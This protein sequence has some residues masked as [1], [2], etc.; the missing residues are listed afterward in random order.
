MGGAGVAA[1]RD[2]ASQIDVE[3]VR[4]TG[5]TR[6]IRRALADPD[7]QELYDT[8]TDRG[9]SVEPDATETRKVPEQ[10]GEVR[11]VVLLTQ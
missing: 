8:Y 11:Y 4:R 9:W 6:A 7:F 3:R 10:N 5:R 1:A 2:R